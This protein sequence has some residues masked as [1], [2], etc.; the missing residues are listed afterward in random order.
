MI[1]PLLWFRLY[2][3]SDSAGDDGIGGGGGCGLFPIMF[4]TSVCSDRDIGVGVVGSR[5]II[6][7]Q[8]AN[9]RV[10]LCLG[11]KVAQYVAQCR[12]THTRHYK[13]SI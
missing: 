1:L 5:F 12:V 10:L 3:S 4:M 9:R 11:V 13:T 2:T 8:I 7:N 6:L